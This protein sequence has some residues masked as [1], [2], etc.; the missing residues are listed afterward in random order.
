VGKKTPGPRLLLLLA[1]PVFF[2]WLGANSI[3]DANEAFY[4]ETPR[5]M[6]LS[7]DYINPTF[8][9][10]PRFNKPV[11][12]YWIVAGLYKALGTSVAVERLGIGVGVM[13]IVFSAFLIGRAIGSKRT[14]VLAALFIATAPRVVMWGRRIFIDVYITAF[15]A[16]ALACFVLAERYP[17]HRRRCLLLMYVAMGLG[18]LTKGPIAVVLPGLVLGVWIVSER[19]WA[20]LGRLHLIAGTAIVLAIVTPWYAATYAEHGWTYIRRFFIDENLGRYAT[21]MV[22]GYRGPVFYLGVLFSDLFPWAPLLVVPLL[23]GWRARRADEASHH[24]S[25]RRLLWWWIVVI[26]GVFS[27]SQTKEDLYIFPVI[28]AVAVLVA[29]GVVSLRPGWERRGVRTFLALVGVLCVVVAVAFTRLFAAGYYA[30]AGTT[31]VALLLGVA[32]ASVLVLAS[33]GRIRAAVTVLAAGFIAFNYVFVARILPDAER[34][35]PIPPIADTFLRRSSPDAAL[36]SYKMMLP[37]LVYYTNHRV[38]ELGS[39]DEAA[40]RLSGNRETWLLTGGAEW[41]ALE[42][43]VPGACVAE[44]RWLFAFDSVNL[45]DIF[46]GVP[47]PEV[48]LVTNKCGA[49][50]P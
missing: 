18:V 13:A 44:R 17:Q 50:A 30:M 14:G 15:M 46:A 29:D 26:V 40:N 4:V 8:N 7:G 23:A 37:S 16:L 32:G 41:T 38:E 36:T 31:P 2:I 22:P 39:E 9:A 10:Q 45:D 11:L 1:L 6:V 42:A 20:D 49:P 19:R 33:V 25:I 3:W 43:R 34:M 28:P 35:K 5:Q 12:S 24:A 27:F 48:L 47:P 21:S